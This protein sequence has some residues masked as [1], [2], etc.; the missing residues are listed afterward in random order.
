MKVF[1][2]SLK[3]IYKILKEVGNIWWYLREN[4][5]VIVKKFRKNM[6]ETS[7]QNIDQNL[8]SL[9]SISK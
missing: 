5:E 4:F 1:L 8:I 9:L 7:D 2:Y 3:K 6:G